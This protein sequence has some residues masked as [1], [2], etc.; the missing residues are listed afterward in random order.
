MKLLILE[1]TVLIIVILMSLYLC[2]MC[3]SCYIQFLDFSE[4]CSAIW[5]FYHT[6]LKAVLMCATLQ[7][8]QIKL[9]SLLKGESVA[10]CVALSV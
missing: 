2:G 4:S 6:F 3:D 10:V 7:G 5:N 8:T 9:K 1:R